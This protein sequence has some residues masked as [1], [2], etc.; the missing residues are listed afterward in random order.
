MAFLDRLSDEGW[1]DD[2]RC[3]ICGADMGKSAELVCSATCVDV[4]SLRVSFRV[5]GEYNYA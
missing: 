5:E 1:D 2:S 3:I 4:Q